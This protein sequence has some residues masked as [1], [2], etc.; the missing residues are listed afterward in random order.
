MDEFLIKFVDFV[1]FGEIF[2][3][4]CNKEKWFSL[5]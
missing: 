3:C 2:K 5:G 1:I 4:L